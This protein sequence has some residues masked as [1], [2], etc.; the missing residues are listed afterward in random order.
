MKTLVGGLG[1]GNRRERLFEGGVGDGVGVS[2]GGVDAE[3]EQVADLADVA[4]VGVDFLEDAVLSE[5]LGSQLGPCPGELLADGTEAWRAADADEKVRVDAA[6]PGR[7]AVV[8]PGGEAGHDGA[9]ERYVAAVEGE[10]GVN[11]VGELEVL[12]LFGREGVEGDQGNGERA[13]RVGRVQGASDGVGVERQRHVAADR[14]GRH[15][16]GWVGEDQLAGLQHCE[17]RPQ[18]ELGEV[19]SGSALGQRGED[20]CGRDLGEGLMSCFGPGVENWYAVI[21]TARTDISSLS[22]TGEDPDLKIGSFWPRIVAAAAFGEPSIVLSDYLTPESGIL[23]KRSVSERLTAI[24]PF[25]VQTGQPQPV[26]ID[27]SIIWMADLLTTSSA[28]PAAQFAA[29][30]TTNGGAQNVNYVRGSIK[31]TVDAVTGQVH[32]Y[33]MDGLIG[34]PDPVL[35]AYASAFPDLFEAAAAMP[36]QLKSHLL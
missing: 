3:A 6:R 8:E 19:A 31:A 12:Y 27:G 14:C 21:D 25:L 17:Q 16:G 32:L 15:G 35:D 28:Y 5:C 2:L 4:A 33:R 13:R 29:V 18:S 34:S 26:I 7:G 1:S 24:A 23:F 11:D 10:S 30:S 9:G 22:A 36:D 20:L